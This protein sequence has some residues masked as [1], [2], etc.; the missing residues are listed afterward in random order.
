MR[1]GGVRR[2]HSLWSASHPPTP[3]ADATV[4]A[5]LKY[6]V[7]VEWSREDACFVAV[8]PELPGCMSH[9]E[10]YGEAIET[11]QEAMDLWTE[12]ARALGRDIPQP[13]GHLLSV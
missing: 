9:G 3:L 10:S 6:T 5:P 1:G 7:V 11:I 13:R 8:A 4:E 12:T 2:P